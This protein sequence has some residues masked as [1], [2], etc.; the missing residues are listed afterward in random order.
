MVEAFQRRM[1]EKNNA[2]SLPP[3]EEAPQVDPGVKQVLSIF[4]GTIIEE[5][6]NEH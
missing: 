5:K 4:R 3:R 6:K 1:A 2:D